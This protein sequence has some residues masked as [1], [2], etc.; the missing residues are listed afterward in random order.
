M[1]V[2]IETLDDLIAALT[3]LR[4]RHGSS[5]P[6]EIFDEDGWVPLPSV[7]VEF[8]AEPECVLLCGRSKR[9]E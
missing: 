7:S 5:I 8:S 3:K 2:T 1:A 4:E 6:V 9:P